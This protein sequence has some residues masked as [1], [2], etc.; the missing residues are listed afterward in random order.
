M[1]RDTLVQMKMKTGVFDARGEGVFKFNI[2][3]LEKGVKR[4]RPEDD[5]LPA[6]KRKL[7]HKVN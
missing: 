7:I 3:G 6:S 2:M 4:A 5:D 1:P